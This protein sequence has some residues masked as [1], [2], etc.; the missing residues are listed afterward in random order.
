MLKVLFPNHEKVMGKNGPSHRMVDLSLSSWEALL[1]SSA[2]L[3][4]SSSAE[5]EAAETN[6][7]LNHNCGCRCWSC[8]SCSSGMFCWKRK[9]WP[10]SSWNSSCFW[11]RNG[12]SSSSWRNG[13][14]FCC[15]CCCSCCC[16]ESSPFTKGLEK[17]VPM[18]VKG[19]N[20]CCCELSKCGSGM[21]NKR[22]V[23][24][25]WEW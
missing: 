19:L 18:K 2:A 23:V 21:I 4:K 7:G 13:S 22:W 10:W 14:F 1:N 12:A 5:D 15:C 3:T 16:C 11:R 8:H 25:K 9:C 17:D 6:L 20:I 24:L